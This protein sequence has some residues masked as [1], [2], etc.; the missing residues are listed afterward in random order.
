MSQM[1]LDNDTIS[2]AIALTKQL[3]MF[4]AQLKEKNNLIVHREI[5]TFFY[6]QKAAELK[7]LVSEYERTQLR[8]NEI[9]GWL[10]EKVQQAVKRKELDMNRFAEIE[11]SLNN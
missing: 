10:D 4:A 3:E 2:R 1:P 6:L 9:S 7:I 5:D 11:Q 8:L